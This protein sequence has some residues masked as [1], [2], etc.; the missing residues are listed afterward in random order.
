MNCILKQV[1]SEQFGGYETVIEEMCS[2]TRNGKKILPKYIVS[3]ATIKNAD[4]QIRCL[5]GR[6]SFSQFPPSG[7]DIGDSYFIKEISLADS[8]FRKYCSVCASG[9]SM[10]T[11]VLRIYA[12]LLQTVKELLN[13]EE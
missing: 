8:P 4:E 9:Q 11:T 6:N 10:K 12:V 7:F 13:D 5:Y 1:L 3:T 2:F